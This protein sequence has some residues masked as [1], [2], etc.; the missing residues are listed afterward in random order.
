MNSGKHNKPTDAEFLQRCL[1]IQS[2]IWS[3]SGI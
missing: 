2:G 1:E 3:G